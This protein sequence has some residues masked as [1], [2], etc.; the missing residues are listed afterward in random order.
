MSPRTDLVVI[1]A[2]L[3]AL[4]VER[5]CTSPGELAARSQDEVFRDS[6]RLEDVRTILN[7]KAPAL[8]ATRYNGAPNEPVDRKLC[9]I[10]LA[11]RAAR[12]V[13]LLDLRAPETVIEEERRLIARALAKLPV[14]RAASLFSD[15]M[16]AQTRELDAAGGAP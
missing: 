14:D 16:D 8:P 13:R 3:L 9:A 6:R 1:P 10:L 11:N 12:L 15:E 2:A 4:L 7:Y 5:L